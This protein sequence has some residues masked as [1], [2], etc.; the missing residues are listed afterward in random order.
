MLKIFF[1]KGLASQIVYDVIKFK[2]SF[3]YSKQQKEN[4]KLKK[5]SV[6]LVVFA[7]ILG[8]STSNAQ[9]YVKVGGGYSFLPIS[10]FAFNDKLADSSGSIT[11]KS[12]GMGVQPVL[13]F[14]YFVTKNIALEL[15]GMYLIGQKH[16]QTPTGGTVKTNGEGIFITPAIRIVAPLKN[17]SPYC[18]MGLVIGLPKVKMESDYSGVTNKFENKG[19]ISLG[20]DAAL[21]IDI[22]ASKML[23]VFIELNGMALN[24][25]PDELEHTENSAGAT[26]PTVT[27]TDFNRPYLALGNFGGKVGISFFF[28]KMPKK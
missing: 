15:D 24:Y 25:A 3:F 23:N 20:M 28:G 18:R 19:G 7:L 27:Y 2:S 26:N 11:Y 16:E 22:K 14:G 6:L 8:Y 4:I 5:L 9:F 17:V 13:G 12:Y 21:G 10:G 1:Y